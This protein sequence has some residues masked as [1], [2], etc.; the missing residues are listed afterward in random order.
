MFNRMTFA[1]TQLL[2]EVL[3]IVLRMLKVCM[4]E[5]PPPAYLQKLIFISSLH[6][7]MVAGGLPFLKLVILKKFLISFQYT[8]QKREIEEG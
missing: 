3:T 6:K 8:S 2:Q 5:P 7:H 4:A 1:L